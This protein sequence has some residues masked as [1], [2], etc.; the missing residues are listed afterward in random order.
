MPRLLAFGDSFTF[1]NDLSDWNDR[2]PSKSTWTALL[3]N[4]L[5]LDYVCLAEPGS[6]NNSIS[7]KVLST[8]INDDDFI[9]LN[10]TWIDR[11]DFLNVD[12]WET[13]RPTGTEKSIFARYYYKYFQNETWDKYET[14]KNIMLIHNFLKQKNINY[15]STAIDSLTLDTRWHCPAYVQTLI[16]EVSAE[17]LWFDNLGFYD[18]ARQKKFKISS[19]MHPLEKAHQAAFKHIINNYEFT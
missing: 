14:L 13:I 11:W 6:S 2:T 12:Q 9:I 18:W 15:L 5:N 8:T 1:G 4:Y 10:W 3:A 7:R 19:S 17:V 16:N